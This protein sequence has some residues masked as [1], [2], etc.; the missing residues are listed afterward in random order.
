MTEFEVFRRQVSPV[1]QEPAV[2][3]QRDGVLLVNDAAYSALGAPD[4]VELLYARRERVMGLRAVDAGTRDAYR[5]RKTSGGPG[6]LVSGRA[7]TN[8]HRIPTTVARRYRAAMS[9]DVLII[10][11]GEILTERRRVV[12]RTKPRPGPSSHTTAEA[13]GCEEGL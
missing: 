3:V 2:T 12:A 8:Y 1:T 5:V 4:A 6:V 13:Q 9:D 10:K 11:L 7:F